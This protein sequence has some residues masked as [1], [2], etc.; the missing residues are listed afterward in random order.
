MRA[1]LIPVFLLVG[2]AA[3]CAS[4]SSVKPVE[5]FDERTG[6]TVSVLKEPIELVPSVR[7]AVPVLQKRTTFAYLG[8]VEWNRSGTLNYGLWMHIAPGDDRQV[9]D[10]GAPGAVT[11]ILDDGPLSLS[12]ME[13]PKLGHG[14]YRQ[15]ASWGQVVYFELDADRLKRMAASRKFELDVRTADGTIIDFSATLDTHTALTQYLNDRG[16]TAD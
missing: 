11:L 9:G 4:Q 15:V 7:N 1:P 5:V 6:I 2:M 16:I 13:A 3:S 14:A 12:T 8:P 10:I